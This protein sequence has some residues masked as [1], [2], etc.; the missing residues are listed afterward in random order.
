M[1]V[2][3]PDRFFL[4]L[5]R[6]EIQELEEVNKSLY[7]LKDRYNAKFIATNDVHYVDKADSRGQDILLAI[8]TGALLSDPNRMRMSGD[9]YYLKS[10]LRW[11]HFC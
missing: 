5:Q 10:P 7:Q 6:H 3:G 4:E 8:Q 11:R 1:E 2:F 9:S